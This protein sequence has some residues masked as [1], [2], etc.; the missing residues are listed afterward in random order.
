MALLDELIKTATTKAYLKGARNT[1]DFV[2]SGLERGRDISDIL[3]A[4][5]SALNDSAKNEGISL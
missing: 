2:V 1:L 4:L 5:R 3:Q